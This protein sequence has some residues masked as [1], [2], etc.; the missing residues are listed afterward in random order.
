ML[1]LMSATM[2]QISKNKKKN[3]NECYYSLDFKKK[4][5]TPILMSVTVF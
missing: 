1:I 5:R 4:K 2:F 3:T